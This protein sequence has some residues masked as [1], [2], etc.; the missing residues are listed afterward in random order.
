MIAENV[1][2]CGLRKWKSGING[3]SKLQWYESKVKPAAERV[4][5]GSF[6]SELLFKVR[7]QSLEVNA[8]TYRW[9]EDGSKECKVCAMGVDESVYHMIVE[10]AEYER[11]R[12]EFMT[13]VRSMEETDIFDDWSENNMGMLL[14]VNGEMKASMEVVKDFLV[15][16]WCKHKRMSERGLNEWQIGRNEH[17]YVRE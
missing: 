15:R 13:N 5:D 14:G 17:N 4:Y 2:E 10:C 9:N 8:R 7:S 12:Q 11:E 3:K 16:I 1:V 6:G